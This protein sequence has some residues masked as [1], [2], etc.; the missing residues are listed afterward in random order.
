[1]PKD[2]RLGQSPD[3][4][5][6]HQLSNTNIW[7]RRT[8]Q[9]LLVDRQ[10]H[11]AL[12]LLTRL[13][14]EGRSPLGRLHA[15]WTLEGLGRLDTALVLK[16][17]DDP[18]PGVRENA[19]RLAE[20]RLSSSPAVI[21][22][23]LNMVTDS[24]PKVRFQLL[25]TLGFVDS[26]SSR[27][28]QGKLLLENIEDV[29]MQVAALSASSDRAPQWFEMAVSPKLKLSAGESPG[30]RSFFRQVCSV[31]GSRQ[32]SG[33]I[34]RVLKAVERNRQS[35]SEWWCAA[36][37]E[38][39][40]SRAGGKGGN[41][42][43]L[44]ASQDLL[45][46]LFEHPAAGVRH[47]SLQ[48]LKEAGLATGAAA[49]RALRRASATASDSDA[50]PLARADA[51]D[52]LSLAGPGERA[53]LFKELIDPQ[54]P[55]RV[56]AAAVRGL[57][58]VKGDEVA[59]FLLSKWRTMTPAVR[60][61]AGYA[62][63]SDPS[64]A[65]L[66]LNAIKNEEVQAWTLDF[67][68]KRALLMNEDPEIRNRAHALLEDQPG[69]REKV[70][71]RY[72]AALDSNGDAARGEQIFKRVCSKCH[73]KNG[74]GAEVGPDLGTVQNRPA[75]LLLE[76]ILMPSKSIAQKYEAYVVETFRGGINEGVLGSQTPTTI[77]LR[78]EEGKEMIIPRKEIKRMYVANL[79]AMPADVEKQVDTQQMADLLKFLTTR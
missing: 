24:N 36:S 49:E 56:Q 32:K 47:A 60:S 72:Q 44:K 64:R 71:K 19:I 22:K 79:S 31:I 9:R 67:S 61:E 30:R 12:G 63:E 26:A 50:D 43:A 17:L 52:L 65:L 11:P 4:E 28:V 15:L 5:L 41:P 55:E 59:R 66:V 33:E 70:V 45:L 53:A 3:A 37:L 74:V 58:Q 46:K 7:W 40:A 51:I 68:Q 10:S 78:K 54:Q 38:G 29:W 34:Q 8:A 39:L 35:G 6:V 73:K 75:A 77:T 23:L 48:L 18:E 57:G 16:A 42:A 2:I 27:A 25:C 1:M 76:D 21:E 13:V 62:L 14:N 69:E 20:P